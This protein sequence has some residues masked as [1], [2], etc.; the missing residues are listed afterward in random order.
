MMKQIAVQAIASALLLSLLSACGSS[1]TTE[2]QTTA[3]TAPQTTEAVTEAGP[4]F[5]DVT[6]GGEDIHFLT[7]ENN[8]YS[9]IEIYSAG[10]DGSLINDTVYNRNMV[11]K[12]E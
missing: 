9:S 11:I 12:N 3:D 7:E 1:G 2:V 4:A 10:A 6:F 8:Q 5:P